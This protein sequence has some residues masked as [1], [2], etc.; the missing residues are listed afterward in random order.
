MS[1]TAPIGTVEERATGKVWPGRWVDVTGYNKLYALGYHTGADLNLNFPHW[2]ANAHS[3]VFAMGDGKVTFAK[4]FPNPKAWGNI[5][6]IDHGIVDGKPLFSRYAHVENIDVAV[7]D[8]VSAGSPIAAVGNGDGLFAYHLH[9]DISLTDILSTQ[10]GHWP[11]SNRRLVHEHYVNP[12]EWLQVHVTDGI[13]NMNKLIAQVYYVI[14][15]LGLR[16]REDHRRSALQVGSLPFGSRV[17]IEDAETVNEDSLTWGRISGGM[18]NGDWIAMGAE[19]Q[20]ETFVSRFS[21]S[22]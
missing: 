12:Q 4:R 21:P 18:F 22:V 10:P 20:S 2:D 14:A 7:G 8:S 1:F 5:I 19:D 3:S 9:F 13:S 15:T 17:S 11:G 16:V 6:V